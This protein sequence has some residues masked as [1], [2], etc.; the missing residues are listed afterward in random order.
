M[1]EWYKK[2]VIENYANFTGRARRAEYWNFVLMNFLI[3]LGLILLA[4]LTAFVIGPWFAMLLYIA[5]AF[6]IIIPSLAAVVR[7]LHDIDKSGWF[8]L[9]SF[10]PLAGPIWLLVMLATE[11]SRGTN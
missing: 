9:V 8:F 11:G 4:F 3:Y 10:I 2:V 1:F 5:Y 7:R 6:G